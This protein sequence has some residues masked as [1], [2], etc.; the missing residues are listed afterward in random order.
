MSEEKKMCPHCWKLN[1]EDL[2][3]G[4]KHDLPE[5]VKKAVQVLYK[6]GVLPDPEHNTGKNWVFGASGKVWPII[7]A[8]GKWIANLPTPNLQATGYFDPF[9]CVSES[10]AN[11][12][13]TLLNYMM[14]INPA[15]RPI[16][17]ELKMIDKNGKA[18]V[19][20]RV[21]AVGSGTIPGKGNSQWAV[22]EW[23]RK[24]GICG[25][26][27][28]PV[29]ENMTEA[30]YFNYDK[31]G[32]P[33]IPE[34]VLKQCKKFC[35][36]MKPT[37]P[38]YIEPYF[39]FNYEDVPENLKDME[40]A[41]KRGTMVSVVGGAV[42]GDQSG[43][44]L[45]RNNGTP[46]YDHQIQYVEQEHNVADFDQVIPTINIVFDTY[47]PFLK[48]YYAKYPFKFVKVIY[49]TLKKKIMFKLAKT[50]SS[51]AVFLLCEASMTRL[52]IADSPEVDLTGGQMLKTMSGSYGNAGIQVISDE[53]MARYDFQYVIKATPKS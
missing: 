9:S 13:E 47:V 43:A 31:N 32:V 14:T 27:F 35:N 42:L 26:E 7:N 34:S 28:W 5:E 8:L 37:D 21:L 1:C 2:K 19:C 52:G 40:E 20:A 53:E 33:Q 3:N 23:F 48:K 39:D 45:Y 18:K 25:E 50:A 46:N 4:V 51:P 6:G 11:A 22:F 30:E 10:L 17:E 41:T 12:I 49:L 29:T 24:N 15:I 38:G 16:L 36:A 44:L